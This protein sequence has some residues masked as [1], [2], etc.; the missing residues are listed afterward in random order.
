VYTVA[1]VKTI[2]LTSGHAPATPLAAFKTNDEWLS[3]LR[4]RVEQVTDSL[5]P[6]PGDLLERAAVEALCESDNWKVTI[7][8]TK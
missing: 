4:W 8:P 1:K 3:A 7:V 6:N 5:V 2:K